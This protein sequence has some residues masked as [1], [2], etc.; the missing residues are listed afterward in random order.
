MNYLLVV[1][2]FVRTPG[3]S[4]LRGNQQPELLRTSEYQSGFPTMALAALCTLFLSTTSTMLRTGEN[5]VLS[6]SPQR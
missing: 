6:S 3:G 1:Q 5:A 4:A 2:V